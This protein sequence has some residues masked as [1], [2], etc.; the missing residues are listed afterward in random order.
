MLNHISISKAIYKVLLFL[1][2][3]ALSEFLNFIILSRTINIYFFN[4]NREY[5]NAYWLV[6]SI[7]VNI[8]RH[9]YSNQ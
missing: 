4:I 5:S 3:A 1:V 2:K 9:S 7:Y 8:Y 6:S